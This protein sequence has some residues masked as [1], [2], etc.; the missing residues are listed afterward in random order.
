[1]LY[2]DQLTQ[3]RF[4]CDVLT[5]VTANRVALEDA[6]SIVQPANFTHGIPEQNNIFL[7]GTYGTL[8]PKILEV[9]PR[10]E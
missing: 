2:L 10:T 1:M 6:G 9:L 8:R 7:V 3:V 4:S 5:N